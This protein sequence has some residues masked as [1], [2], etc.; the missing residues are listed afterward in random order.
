MCI[1]VLLFLVATETTTTCSQPAL[2]KSVCLFS[3]NMSTLR[4]TRRSRGD[5]AGHRT[6]AHGG[7]QVRRLCVTLRHFNVNQSADPEYKVLDIVKRCSV[8]S[9]SSAAGRFSSN[10]NDVRTLLCSGA[11]VVDRTPDQ[12]Q[13]SRVALCLQQETHLFRLHLDTEHDSLTK[14][15]V[16]SALVCSYR[17]TS[18]T[19]L[20]H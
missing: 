17:C 12:R 14:R 3:L 10:I 2:I 18:I 9:Q 11:S 13:D 6:T 4:K 16:M 7:L 20:T 8:D 1:T 19:A 5:P 15:K